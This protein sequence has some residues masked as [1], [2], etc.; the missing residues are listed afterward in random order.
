VNRNT[1][2]RL[3]GVERRAYGGGCGQQYG[4]MEN[5]VM[6]QVVA[7]RQKGALSGKAE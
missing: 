7:R 2:A 4:R 1:K 6:A 3:S 5:A